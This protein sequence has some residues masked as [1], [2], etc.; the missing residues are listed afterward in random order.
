[1]GGISHEDD[2]NFLAINVVPLNPV[3]TNHTW[4][5]DPVCRATKVLGV[6]H[7]W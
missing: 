5:L 2:W 3:F 7:Q 6:T 1:M 4:E